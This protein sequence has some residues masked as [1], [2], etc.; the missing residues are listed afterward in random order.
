MMKLEGWDNER[1]SQKVRWRLRIADKTGQRN[2][3]AINERFPPGYLQSINERLRVLTRDTGAPVDPLGTLSKPLRILRRL[4]EIYA[5]AD[6]L[7]SFNGDN[8]ACR[9][10]CNHCCHIAVALTD[11][12]AQLVGSK[13]GRM[14]RPAGKLWRNYDAS[15]FDYGYHNPCTF[16]RDGEC[17]IYENRPLACRTL[18]NADSDPLLC[19]LTPPGP[20]PEVPYLNR[21]PLTQAFADIG[22]ELGPMGARIADIREYFPKEE[23]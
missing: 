16:L 23:G 14:P 19:E 6:E 9:R 3:R 22:L 5:I 21:M 11:V 2:A 15:A 10:G 17:S 13:I 4:S 8:V 20:G 12:E 18:L 7:N 1:F